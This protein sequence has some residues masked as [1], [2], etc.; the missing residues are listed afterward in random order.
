MLLTELKEQ[1][2]FAV[3]VVATEQRARWESGRHQPKAD[4]GTGKKCMFVPPPLLHCA[5]WQD[6]ICPSRLGHT[7]RIVERVANPGL[8]HRMANSNN[9][10]RDLFCR[11]CPVH[12]YRAFRCVFPMVGLEQQGNV[13]LWRGPSPKAGLKHRVFG[14]CENPSHSI[15]NDPRRCLILLHIEVADI[16]PPVEK[17]ELSRNIATRP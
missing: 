1:A 6:F 4:N 13:Q 14:S 16:F 3:I 15:V 2:P 12:E 5:V 10:R 9:S 17:Q 11:F 8:A 7:Q